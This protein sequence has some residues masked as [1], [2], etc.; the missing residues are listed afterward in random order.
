MISV[1]G[2]DKAQTW[3]TLPGAFIG[4]APLASAPGPTP[5]PSI[6]NGYV[7]FGA[8]GPAGSMGYSALDAYASVITAVPG[9]RLTIVNELADIPEYRVRIIERMKRDGVDE[10]ALAFSSATA[11]GEVLATLKNIDIVLDSFPTPGFLTAD[12]AWQGVFSVGFGGGMHPIARRALATYK[13]L[14][15]SDLVAPNRDDFVSIAVDLAQDAQRRMDFRANARSA[16][17]GIS[18]FD[19]KGFARDFAAILRSAC[20]AK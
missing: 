1:D 4:S 8:I 2:A 16:Y 17:E 5:C 19:G 15:M 12:I 18:L 6:A 14:S 20:R 11:H 3:L 10:K 7:T 9:S 13:A